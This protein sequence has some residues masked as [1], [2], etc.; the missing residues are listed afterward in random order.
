[1][2]C[3][4]SSV[5]STPSRKALCYFAI[6]TNNHKHN[7]TTRS[8]HPRTSVTTRR[9]SIACHLACTQQCFDAHHS[10]V[11][12]VTHP[13]PEGGVAAAAAVGQVL[14]PHDGAGVAFRANQVQERSVCQQRRDNGQRD[15]EKDHCVCGRVCGR[16]CSITK[17][18]VSC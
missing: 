3:K 14:W 6:T 5:I 15:D 16:V 9:T 4:S 12:L 17:G 13:P 2:S 18:C 1:M 11:I 7:N 8:Q 10:T